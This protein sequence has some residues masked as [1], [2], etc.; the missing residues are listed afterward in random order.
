MIQNTPATSPVSGL[1]IG[2]Q[3]LAGYVITLV[4]TLVLVLVATNAL[5]SVSEAKDVVIERDSTLV[6]GVYRLDGIISDW[7]AAN[8]AFYLTRD[9][10]DLTPAREFEQAYNEKFD[11]LQAAVHTETGRRLLDQVAQA[12]VA[13]KAASEKVIDE[14]IAGA[15]GEEV[16]R[17]A[18]RGPF[19]RREELRSAVHRFIDRQESLITA[20]VRRADQRADRSLELVWALAAL[21]LVV[22]V[23]LTTL[24]TR[25]V[26][27][28]LSSLSRTVD[29]AAS[30]IL[31]GTTQQVTGF[32][33]QAA[34]AQQTVATVEELVQTAQQSAQ[35]ARTVAD[36]AQRS[37]EVAQDGIK[38][39]EGSA[40]G[41]EA[42]RTQVDSIAQGVVTLAE[43][44]QA[45]SHIV[46]TVNEIA[47]QTH[48]L[49]LNAAI[50]AAR[51]G[52]HGRGF[53]VV[54]AEVKGLADQSRRATAQVN[55]ILGE[56]QQG[57]NSAV[58]LTEAGTKSV[59][60]GMRLV[61]QAG[62]T[63]TELSDTVAEATVAAEQIA[64]SSN[65]QAVAT[66]QISQAMK[67]IDSVMEQNLA[68]AREAEQTARELDTVSSQMKA[69]VG[70][71]E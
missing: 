11:Q 17:L 49:A 55:E 31:A 44:A 35:R 47:E 51:A 57:T 5:N 54:A 69:L 56:I 52:E 27:K 26:S 71:R 43:R 29:G 9:E 63:I 36:R 65:Q 10:G 4:L 42:I 38:A 53:G 60:E 59:I 22:A 18:S 41:M 58:M 68:S 3:I 6:T 30:D 64:A 20:D 70:V 62:E 21:V 66:S 1:T 13:W 61:G 34:A 45:V 67:E 23:F 7:A 15:P 50:E 37:A 14:V 16:G 8:R 48:L 19:K 25:R 46:D 12:E 32:T 39:V 33:E 40:R 28:C 2:R 24:I